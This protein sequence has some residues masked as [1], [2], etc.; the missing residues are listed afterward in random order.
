MENHFAGAK[1]TTHSEGS[2]REQ[3]EL[4]LYP[5]EKRLI[6]VVNAKLVSDVEAW[7]GPAIELPKRRGEPFGAEPTT[8]GRYRVGWI[9]R[10]QTSSWGYSKIRWGTRLKPHPTDSEDV[11]YEASVG[12]WLSVKR[13]TL[14][15][16]GQIKTRYKELYGSFELPKTWVFND[17]G[18]VAI[19][20]YPDLNNNRRQDPNEPLSGQMFHT[21]VE[22]E[23]KHG[24]ALYPSHGCIHLRPM[25]RDTLL[26]KLHAFDKGTLIVIHRYD[27]TSGLSKR[28][29]DLP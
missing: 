21:T 16:R 24:A 26:K 19:R 23:A 2:E 10:Y 25:D 28:A 3:K 18:P 29:A 9:G 11:L 27:E 17:F 1:K 14:A 22:S 7:G 15:T 5:G 6:Y 20:Y 13:L 8:A 4:H 12:R